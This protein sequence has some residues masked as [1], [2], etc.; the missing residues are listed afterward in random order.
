[1]SRLRVAPIVEGDGEVSCIRILLERVWYEMLRGEYINVV[2]PVKEHR[3]GII[4]GDVL[5]KAV[6]SA[7]LKLH[8][9][10]ASND[11]A[12]VLILI[13]ADEDCPR[14]LGPKLIEIARE[15]YP[16]T[17]VACILAKVEYETWFAA[18]AESLAEYLDL[19]AGLPAPE[20]PEEAR[21][22]K[23]WVED[24]FRKTKQRSKY[25][26]TRDQPAMTSVMDLEIC[27][28]RS[29]SFNKLCRELEQRLQR[30][31]PVG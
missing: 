16:I 24:R 8:K 11:P 10:P 18:A 28:K 20:S 27:R 17:D 25:S 2:Q 14:E 6:R 19:M 15:V 31:N 7:A 26:E 9:S 5:R 4:K 29:P 30:P 22:G 1:M 23:K 3:A 13:D 21:H 12:L